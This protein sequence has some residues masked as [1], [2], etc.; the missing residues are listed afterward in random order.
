MLCA[1]WLV[2]LVDW[3]AYGLDALS[4][5]RVLVAPKSVDADKRAI[6][7]AHWVWAKREERR[8]WQGDGRNLTLAMTW[9]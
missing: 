4:N 2:G 5:T 6:Q 3:W 8:L 1:G 9:P 7:M